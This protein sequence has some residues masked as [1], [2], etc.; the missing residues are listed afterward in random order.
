[1]QPDPQDILLAT[2]GLLPLGLAVHASLRLLYGARGPAPGDG[3]HHVLRVAGWV[4]IAVGVLIAS[5][6]TLGFSVILFVI[7]AQA[8][9]ELVLARRAHARQAAWSVVSDAARRGRPLDEAARIAMEGFTGRIRRNF[10]K[11]AAAL[12]RGE[13]PTAAIARHQ[14]AFPPFALGQAALAKGANLR[15]L[16]PHDPADATLGQSWT[17]IMQR[18]AYLFWLT[19]VAVFILTG[20]FTYVIP[21]FRMIFDDFGVEL[22]AMTETLIWLGETIAYT[23][24]VSIAGLLLFVVVPVTLFILWL[25][26][27]LDFHPLR[28]LTDRLFFSR[29]RVRVL[30]LLAT[31]IDEGQP[32]ERA[33][34]N[35]SAGAPQYPSPLIAR[36]LAEVLRKTERGADYRVALRQASL[37]HPA[38]LPLLAA[39]ESAGNLPWALRALADRALARSVFRW[40]A[41]QQFLFPLAI[42]AYGILIGWIA[43]AL[44][45]PLVSLISNLT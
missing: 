38:E 4:L 26:Y 6:A 39:A 12:S 41:V 16:T 40:N 43:I 8:G 9:L 34:E 32:L 21:S 31:A 29:H 35:L 14:S 42:L 7:I 24:I 44:F 11:F 28:P 30:R 15:L 20:T 27:L 33:L 36:R 13:E 3:V 45:I 2:F 37:L 5:L 1:M 25:L 19:I 10:G 17:L 18:F 23:P 22:P